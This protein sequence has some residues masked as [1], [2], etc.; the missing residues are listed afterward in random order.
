LTELQDWMVE[1]G[2]TDLR[3]LA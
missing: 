3:S 1:S 2:V